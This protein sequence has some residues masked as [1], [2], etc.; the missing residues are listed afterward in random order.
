MVNVVKK[1]GKN[2]KCSKKSKKS[3]TDAKKLLKNFFFQ[4]LW[5]FYDHIKI[6]KP[7]KLKQ[8]NFGYFFE[9]FNSF[10]SNNYLHK[11]LFKINY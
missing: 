5:I 2:S 9:K 11:S 7:M 10:I 6:K 1:I 3:F 8:I 4:F